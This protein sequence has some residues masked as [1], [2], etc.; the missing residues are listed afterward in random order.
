MM[1]A[2][3]SLH[4]KNHHDMRKLSLYASDIAKLRLLSANIEQE[5]DF[6]TIRIV[7]ISILSILKDRVQ[8]QEIELIYL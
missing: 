5:E 1:I 3:M 8:Y 2:P 7:L 4:F 6:K